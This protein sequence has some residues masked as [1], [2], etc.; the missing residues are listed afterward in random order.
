MVYNWTAYTDY[1]HFEYDPQDID[2]EFHLVTFVTYHG[3]IINSY[4][5]IAAI[6]LNLFHILILIQKQMRS[7][8]IFIY[9]LAVAISDVISFI[10]SFLFK[11]GDNSHVEIMPIIQEF[12]DDFWCFEDPWKPINFLLQMVYSGFGICKKV[13]ILLAIIMAVIRTLSI[14]FPMSNKIQNMA[15]HR[16]TFFVIF[17][18]VLVSFLLETKVI[19]WNA[20]IF[21]IKDILG[22][23]C[24]D[25][26][27]EDLEKY[28]LVVPQKILLWTT[29]TSAM[30]E[31]S[32]KLLPAAIYPV[33]TIFLIR[34][35]KAIKNRRAD[36]RSQQNQNTN[37]TTSLITFMTIVFMIT[38]MWAGIISVLWILNNIWPEIFNDFLSMTYISNQGATLT[39]SINSISHP[40]VCILMSTQYRDTLRDVFYGNAISKKAIKLMK[41]DSGVSSKTASEVSQHPSTFN[42]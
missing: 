3:R 27:K 18:V 6:V 33:L 19:L 26:P 17:L 40:I 25:P 36:M 31:I 22:N 8:A 11:E 10:L 9:M 2:Y 41:L 13:S 1:G 39:R 34:E 42:S 21:R 12:N 23:Y 28:V 30:I 35:L 24:P 20:R 4:F 29:I 14:L 5:W 16:M 38:E 37:N 7:S 15:Q 32:L